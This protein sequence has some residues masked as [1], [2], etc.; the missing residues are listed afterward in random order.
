MRVPHLFFDPVTT[1]V[2]AA[3]YALWIIPELVIARRRPEPGAENLDRGSKIAVIVAVNLGIFLGFIAAGTVSS[4][5]VRAHWRTMFALGIAVWLCGISLRLYSV[6][7]LGRFFTTDVTISTGQHVVE[8]GPYRWL[9]HPSYLGGLLALL[10]FGITLTNWL[11]IALPVSCLAAA[12][13]YRIPIEE[14]ALVH[15]LGSE[16]SEYM[17]RTRRLIPYV[18]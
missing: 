11:A 4:L 10:G 5:T 16:Y 17:L 18:F 1:L 9:R 15:G 13:L 7:V 8:R 3:T 12:Y 6:H 14:T 2:W